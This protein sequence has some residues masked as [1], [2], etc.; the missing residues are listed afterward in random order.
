MK[1]RILILCL[2]MACLTG[3]FQ[4]VKVPID[5]YS[6]EMTTIQGNGDGGV[7]AC[8]PELLQQNEGAQALVLRCQAQDGVLTLTDATNKQGYSGTYRVEQAAPEAT[9]YQIAIGDAAGYA[10][11][12]MTTFLDGSQSPTFIINIGGYALNFHAVAQ[13]EEAPSA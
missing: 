5:S 8:A 9:T 10:V 13:G 11:T 1:T 12:G 3:C 6:W 4:S 7:V 2:V